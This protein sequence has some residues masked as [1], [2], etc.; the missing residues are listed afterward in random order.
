MTRWLVI[1]ALAAWMSGTSAQTTAS[2]QE[3]AK[4]RMERSL[5]Q[6]SNPLRIIIDASKYPQRKRDADAAAPAEPRRQPLSIEPPPRLAPS[7]PGAAARDGATQRRA[8]TAGRTPTGIEPPASSVTTGLAGSS[9]PAPATSTGGL[10][11]NERHVATPAAEST[12]TE[13]PGTGAPSGKPPVDAPKSAGAVPE[14]PS[15]FNLGKPGPS[16]AGLA[17]P[18]GSLAT[19]SSDRQ[20]RASGVGAPSTKLGGTG[21][22][23]LS[24]HARQ[25]QQSND[26]PQLIEYVEPAVPEKVRRRLRGSVE[27]V[28]EFWINADGSTSSAVVQTGAPRELQSSVLDAVRRWRFSAPP[29][30]LKTSVQ[31]VFAGDE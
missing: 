25:A 24:S 30:P 7:Q 2:N 11:A 18:P 8:A 28:V 22:A 26:G 19:D 1:G 17:L 3:D 20:R 23:E 10:A 15:A 27:V 29:E 4:E 9:G 31:L 12:S 5:R 16:G 6:A 14:P 13:A 21:P